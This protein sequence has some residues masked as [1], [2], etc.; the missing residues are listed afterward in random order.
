MAYELWTGPSQLDGSPIVVLT[1]LTSTNSKTGDVAQAYILRSDVRPSEAT[2]TGADS[3]ICGNCQFKP[4]NS[5]ACYV[6]P[7]RG[8]DRIYDDWAKNPKPLPRWGLHNRGLRI[9]AYGDPAAVPFEVWEAVA[10]VANNV[11]GFTHQWATCDPRFKQLCMA[12]CE[13]EAQAQSAQS[14]GWRTYRVALKDQLVRSQGEILCPHY[15]VGLTCAVCQACDGTSK[16][17][18]ANIVAPVHGASWKVVR[19]ERH[20]A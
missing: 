13:T 18:R 14:M 2:K 19:F 8:P 10:K 6:L 3:S 17:R 5:G 9:G 12:S 16:N 20:V 1:T 11:T 15:K 7:F 4:S